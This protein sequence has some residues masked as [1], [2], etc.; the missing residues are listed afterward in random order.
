MTSL[1][2]A[3]VSSVG[4]HLAELLELESALAGHDVFWVLNDTS[5][6]LPEGREH[7]RVSHAERDL[8]VIWN[9]VEF[10]RVFLKT[11]PDLML[12]MGAGPAVPAAIISKLMG[13]PVIYIEPSSA[14]S[15]P[16]L[17]GR[18]MRYLTDRRYVQWPGLLAKLPGSR[19]AGGLL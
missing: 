14:V 12:S 16:T 13:I 2:I 5:P 19:F 1:R 9:L 18:L 11:R 10:T 4:G 7:Y 15:A 17:T 6:V 3:L 8:K